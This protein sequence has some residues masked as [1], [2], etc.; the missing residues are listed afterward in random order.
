MDER[1]S[2]WPLT[3]VFLYL[4]LNSLSIFIPIFPQFVSAGFVQIAKMLIDKH[5]NLNIQDKDGYT[6]LTKA[7][8]RSI[9]FI[10]KYWFQL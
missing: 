9:F 8:Y 7:V 3:M 1:L 2:I 10:L 6:P 5:A 4:S